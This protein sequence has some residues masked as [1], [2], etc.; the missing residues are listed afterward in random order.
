M[1][2]IISVILASVLLSFATVGGMAVLGMDPTGMHA[3]QGMGGPD[4]LSHCLGAYSSNASGTAPAVVS[5]GLVTTFFIVLLVAC[6]SVDGGPL[7]PRSRWRDDIGKF[8]LAR[9]MAVVRI[10][11]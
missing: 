3:E 2:K 7:R 9:Q 8:L 10:Q 5:A 11:D 4:C 1:R 6:V